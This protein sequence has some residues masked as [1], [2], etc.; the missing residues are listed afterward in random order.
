MP[1][2]RTKQATSLSATLCSLLALILAMI[3]SPAAHAEAV[4]LSAIDGELQLGGKMQ[5]LPAPTQSTLSDVMG[6]DASEWYV[7][8]SSTRS[9]GRDHNSVW[10]H[11]DIIGDESSQG[12]MV[13][14]LDYPHYDYIDLYLVSDNKVLTSFHTGDQMD[15]ETRPINSRT[16]T[17]PL[18]AIQNIG[19]AE[20]YV[21]IRTEG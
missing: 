2:L 16:F 17:F 18:D 15:F 21:H 12:P 13:L 1:E 11:L 5:Y 8:P 4:H 14:R 20:I 9:L 6:V 10:F 19:E 3:F 7:A